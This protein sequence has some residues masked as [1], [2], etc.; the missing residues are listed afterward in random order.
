[1]KPETRNSN[2]LRPTRRQAL[3]LL[4]AGATAAAGCK[5]GLLNGY[6]T[7]PNYDPGIRTVYV[8]EF[9]TKV[10]ETTPYRGMEEVLTRKVV[11]EIEWKTP[12]KV[13]SDPDGADTELQGTIV[14][15]A[16]LLQNR[17]RF[18][19]VRELDLQ[20]TVEIVWHDLRPGN[21]GRILTNPTRR[22]NALPQPEASFDLL[23]PPPPP[24]PDDPKPVRLFADGRGLI[25]LGETSTSALNM[26]LD[27]LAVQIVSAMEMPWELSGP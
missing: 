13:V 17:T 2:R 8:P 9:K 16:K 21:E 20:V 22:E 14:G 4:L 23:N 25:E 15:L 27:R 10:F 12:F 5:H 24:K 18:N 3:A 26:A 19:E 1:L 7:R 6:T 11:N